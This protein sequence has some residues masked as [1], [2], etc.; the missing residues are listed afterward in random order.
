M[1]NS[2]N[3]LKHK[4]KIRTTHVTSMF[5]S[6]SEKCMLYRRKY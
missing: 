5:G 2:I 1:Y 4:N 6:M 3:M